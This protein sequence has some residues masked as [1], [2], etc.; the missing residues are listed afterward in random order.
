[1]NYSPEVYQ[2]IINH[3]KAT[4]GQME[5][6]IDIGCGPGLATR[7]L[8]PHFT[9]AYGL[10][11]SEGMIAKARSLTTES[12]SNIRFEVSTAEELGSNL[13]PRVKDASVD[14][15]TA[16]NAAHWFNM[17]P[18]WKAAARVL[19]PGGTV[20]LWTSGGALAHPDMPNADAI[21]KVFD[22]HYE[23]YLRPYL[24]PGNILARER[25]VD[26]PLPWT[27]PEP[28]EEFDESGFVRREW[29][30]DERFYT[31]MPE[32]GVSLN[33]FEKMTST[34]SAITRWREAHPELVGTEK[35]IIR[36]IRREIERL[37]HE[38]GVEEGKERVKGVMQGAV[39][40]LKKKA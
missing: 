1:M 31:D 10:D 29:G 39:L 33:V 14:L 13:S 30:V 2:Y 24:T 40:L 22:W 7:P 18:F 20:A 15:I 38:A 16:A 9:Q 36:V 32:D 21:Q 12:D 37:L 3:H 25:Y 11:P 26:L 28:I 8:A 35:D 27:I 4:G 34:G 19:K 17:P 6:L 5:T 23:E